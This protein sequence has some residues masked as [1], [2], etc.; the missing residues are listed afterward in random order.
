VLAYAEDILEDLA[1]GDPLR[2]DIGVIIRETMRCRDIVRNLLDFARQEK[3]DL[4][5]TNPN[6]IIEQSLSL[7]HKLPQFRNITID[8]NLADELPEIG[9]DVH[10]IQQ[11]LLN[12]MINAADAMNENGVIKL[13]TAYDRQQGRCLI[14]VED[15]GPGVPPNLLDR[16]FEPFFSTKGTNGL[17]LAVSWGII[18][19]HRGVIEVENIPGGGAVFRI[20]LPAAG[21]VGRINKP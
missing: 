16:I 10:Q 6:R 2:G 14:A 13:S 3:L 17:G 15:N 1:E 19:R 5:R 4:E 7:V 20:V 9:C 8:Q 21:N 18:E 11:V 12:L